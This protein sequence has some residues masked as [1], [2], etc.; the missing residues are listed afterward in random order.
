METLFE[1]AV[2]RIGIDTIK[3]K[4]SRN[5]YQSDP[6]DQLVENLKSSLDSNEIL[7][8]YKKD[9]GCHFVKE[10]DSDCHL[11]KIYKTDTDSGMIEIF[12]MC[13][14]ITEFKLTDHHATILSV[15][16]NLT[17]DIEMKLEKM[18]VPLD[19]FYPNDRSFVFDD[20][21]RRQKP[22]FL[23]LLNYQS[24]C[25]K[26]YLNDMSMTTIRLPKSRQE[27]IRFAT[28]H[29]KIKSSEDNK[30]LGD[31]YYRWVKLTSYDIGT[32][33]FSY[34]KCEENESSHFEIKINDSKI[35]S[36]IRKLFNK[37]ETYS[38]NYNHEKQTHI[39]IGAKKVSNIKYNKSKKDKEYH[40]CMNDKYK[41]IIEEM[42]DTDDEYNDLMEHFQHT[43]VEL[44]FL[45][46]C[47]TS[48]QKKLLNI[49]LESSYGEL[50]DLIKKEIEKMTIFILKP[51]ISIDDYVDSYK[52]RLKKVSATYAITSNDYGKILEVTPDVWS[53]FENQINV[54]KSKFIPD[55][56]QLI[57]ENPTK[58]W[59]RSPRRRREYVKIFR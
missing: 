21:K 43:R 55:V 34:S 45:K 2:I 6:I 48:T 3:I 49:N 18:D 28:K 24:K 26:V 40:G 41:A 30:Q 47:V 59:I 1:K 13:Q 52:K 36:E 22:Y 58:L 9:Y 51:D 46:P 27:M 4:L 42:A 35:Y 38:S 19:F 32:G 11:S 20:S 23:D 44:R 7:V 56:M 10:I 54:L 29:P 31:C 37:T 50:L 39:K 12:G 17:D 14:T 5:L 16:G 33:R 15:V 53:D 8:Y 25:D 57:P